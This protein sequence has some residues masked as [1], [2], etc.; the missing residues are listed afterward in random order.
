MSSAQ[1]RPAEL[2]FNGKFLTKKSTGVHRVAHEML[3]AIGDILAA[4]S[5]PHVQ[6]TVAAPPGPCDAL[7]S[8]ELTLVKT[9]WV[10]G[11]LWEQLFLP[12]FV[13]RRRLVNLCNLAP[14]I[15]PDVIM[16]HDAQI[17]IS[18]ESYTRSFVLLYR[19]LQPLIARRASQIVT[20]SAYS[21]DMLVKYRLAPASRIAV[22]HNGADHILRV[23]PDAAIIGRLA[24]TPGQY[25]VAFAST[26]AHKNIAVLFR[27]FALPLLAGVPL[28]LVGGALAPD[29]AA[30]GL[31][32]PPNIL[33]AGS[34]SD[35]A[36]RALLESAACMAFPSTTEGFGL[37]PLEAMWLG[38][39]AI[40]APCGA[41]PE[42]CGA[43]AT[44]ANP[45]DPAAWAAAI[46][47]FAGNPAAREEAGTRGRAHAAGFTWQRAA[48]Q[49]LAMLGVSAS[50]EAGQL[51]E[52]H[53]LSQAQH[54]R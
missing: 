43:A 23:P 49:L 41:L 38:C 33:F 24:L 7:A 22:I 34:V 12:R 39:P 26:M 28:V 30:S 37:P 29:F 27:A 10:R 19:M 11:Q 32:Y 20:V 21:R 16:I 35:S 3:R 15:R 44:Y 2:I 53:P 8:P 9:G 46:A 54:D 13:R 40:V 31:A 50:A 51:R 25:A 52:T 5:P 17:H 4:S 47:H 45:H 18:P 1:P 42:I 36:L 48:Q 6:I 14:L